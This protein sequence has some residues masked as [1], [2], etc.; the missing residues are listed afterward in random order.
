METSWLEQMTYAQSIIQ[1]RF[2]TKF[3]EIGAKIDIARTPWQINPN[4]NSP[5][6]QE[7]HRAGW[8]TFL[9][10]NSSYSKRIKT[11]DWKCQ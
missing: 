2:C 6:K 3:K 10:F 11:I 8:K 7:P 5:S 1:H 9:P 4:V